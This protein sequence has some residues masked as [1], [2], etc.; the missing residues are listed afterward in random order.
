[1]VYTVEELIHTDHS[2]RQDLWLKEDSEIKTEN[3][4][5]ASTGNTQNGIGQN[6]EDNV[7]KLVGGSP[8]RQAISRQ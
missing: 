3:A 4:K 1:M 5:P 2:R 8:S 6:N 7:K